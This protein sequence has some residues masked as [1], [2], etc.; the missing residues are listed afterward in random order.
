[1]HLG[2]LVYKPFSAV[3]LRDGEELKDKHTVEKIEEKEE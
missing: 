1:M 2:G 3:M